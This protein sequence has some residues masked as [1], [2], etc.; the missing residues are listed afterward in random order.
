MWFAATNGDSLFKSPPGLSA[1]G[2]RSNRRWV[3]HKVELMCVIADMSSLP[4]TCQIAIGLGIASGWRLFSADVQRRSMMLWGDRVPL[5]A[6][7]CLHEALIASLLDCYR[8]FSNVSSS[9]ISSILQLHLNIPLTLS[10]RFTL[11]SSLSSRPFFSLSRIS[12]AFTLSSSLC[13]SFFSNA[14]ISFASVKRDCDRSS[15]SA[16][17]R[18]RDSS[19]LCRSSR[20]CS[21]EE[22]NV[23]SVTGDDVE[24]DG[25]LWMGSEG[26]EW[27][28]EWDAGWGEPPGIGGMGGCVLVGVAVNNVPAPASPL[29]L[30][31][32]IK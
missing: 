15:T 20:S 14:T 4:N 8:L 26:V 6:M 7:K 28:A 2:R 13:L 17:S 19:A 23:A 5:I 1:G 9:I 21:S 18:F 27:D 24:A 12:N 10:T 29:G 31:F 22:C 11:S 16:C 3:D 32:R 30:R 25:E